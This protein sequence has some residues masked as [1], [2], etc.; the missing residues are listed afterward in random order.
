MNSQTKKIF[1]LAIGWVCFALGAVAIIVPVLPTTPFM[2]LAAACFSKGS[3]RL[4]KWLLSLPHVGD[5]VHDWEEHG[6]VRKRTKIFASLMIL[7][8]FTG[9]IIMMWENKVVVGAMAATG[10]AV[11]IFINTRPSRPRT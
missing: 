11:L 1:F 9:T 8:S 3:E 4:H 6:V 2:I 10:A 7:V 5:K